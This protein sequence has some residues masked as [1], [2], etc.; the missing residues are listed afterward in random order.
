MRV[1]IT[2]ATGLIGR[3]LAQRLLG[4]GHGV[5]ALARD[6]QLSRA[7]LGPDVE[8]VPAERIVEALERVDAVV[9]LAGEPVVG[10]R[11]SASQ[12]RE[13]V[14][15]R[16]DLTHRLVAALGRVTRRPA[17]LVSASAVG[18]Y[19]DR[20][21]AELNEDSAPGDGFLAGLCRDWEA[22]ALGARA[23]GMRVVC[24]RIGL[25][26]STESGALAS[27]L[28]AFRV[29]AGGPIG[30]GRQF[31][32]W[33]H[34][35]DMVAM[36]LA[37]LSDTRWDGAVNA[38]A[39]APVRQRELAQTLGRVLGRPAF[40]P[41]PGFALRVLL[42]EAGGVLLS[43]QRALPTRALGWGFAFAW[44]SLEPALGALV[45]PDDGITM[46]DVTEAPRSAYL[47]TRRPR[48][49][50]RQVIDLPA[51]VSDVFRF[52]SSAANLG[53]VTPSWLSWRIKSPVPEPLHAGA[54]I[55]YAIRLGPL[56]M[57]W[58]TV[59][60]GWDA[61]RFFCDAQE[62]GPYAAWWHEHRFESHAGGTR[63]V[64]D[65]FYAVPLGP[66]GR[67][68]H[69]LFVGPTLRAI[70]RYRREAILRLFPARA[71]A[72]DAQGKAGALAAL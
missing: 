6:A 44:P 41:A 71:S 68:V 63:V 30:S 35:D 48:H 67:L 61:G 59:I 32:P 42:G 31:Y 50:L 2:G 46:D 36:I 14:T 17:V 10:K 1:F 38:T 52:F 62:R 8:L 25:V 16:V 43:S 12:K 58:R 11:W 60:Q 21:D 3:A 47:E 66:L 72:T 49:H 33:I 26:L 9:N 24:L 15:S 18:F 53:L 5:V 51:P 56:P 27:M 39:P 40:V 55:D 57:T 4:A 20:A 65:V 70:F 29:G 22:A 54:T 23:I 34:L 37:A 7:R 64:D 19:G 69:A 13:L 28:P 45:R